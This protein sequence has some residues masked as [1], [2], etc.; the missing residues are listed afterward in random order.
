MF[1]MKHDSL[2]CPDTNQPRR[3]LEFLLLP[4][5]LR[6]QLLALYANPMYAD[7]LPLLLI[8]ANELMLDAIASNAAARL[9]A[10]VPFDT[11][12]T[13]SNGLG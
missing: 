11:G 1:G 10:L 6:G 7:Q 2:T 3:W 12:R 8:C 9:F 4:E 13:M 5:H